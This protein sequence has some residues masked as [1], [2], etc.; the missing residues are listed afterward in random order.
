MNALQAIATHSKGF[1]YAISRVGITGKQQSMTAD[2]ASLVAR[3]R[4]W[5]KL[6]VA[7]GFG[8]SNANHVA[9]V[10]E[11]ADAAVDRQRHCG[12][13]RTDNFRTGTGSSA[14]RSRPIYQGPAPE[15][16]GAG[17]V[18]IAVVSSQLS[19]LSCIVPM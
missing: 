10:A 19:A 17:P 6:P 11:F 3:I 16:S 15:R 14:R 1:V 5:S 18:K 8:I 2:A 7:V 4:R 9:Q 13:S 12:V